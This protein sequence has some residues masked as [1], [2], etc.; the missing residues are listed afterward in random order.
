MTIFL[1]LPGMPFLCVERSIDS[2]R[3]TFSLECLPTVWSMGWLSMQGTLLS[4]LPFQ[5]EALAAPE[6]NLVES[7]LIRLKFQRDPLKSARPSR[8]LPNFLPL[9]PTHLQSLRL[10]NL[11]SLFNSKQHRRANSLE[12]IQSAF[13]PESQIDSHQ[14]SPTESSQRYD[15]AMHGRRDTPP[16]LPDNVKQTSRLIDHRKPFTIRRNND[17]PESDSLG[18][19]LTGT[20]RGVSRVEIT[21]QRERYSLQPEFSSPRRAVKLSLNSVSG[22]R[23]IA[24]S[25]HFDDQEVFSGSAAYQTHNNQA[26]RLMGKDLNSRQLELFADDEGEGSLDSGYTTRHNERSLQAAGIDEEDKSFKRHRDSCDYLDDELA[27]MTY[28][29]LRHQSF[30]DDPLKKVLQPATPLTG[31]TLQAKLEHF[32]GQRE[33]DQQKFFTQMNVSDWQR[34]GDWLLDRFGEVAQKLKES[35]KSKR[36]LVD[37]FESEISSR[38]ETVRQQTESIIKKL[39]KIKHK[40]EDMLADKEI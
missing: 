30:D 7:T 24:P 16:L 20:G 39:G 27:G 38:E 37:Q 5:M 36:D 35:R 28:A 9:N 3:Q 21:A 18:F 40:G 12:T 19:P 29:M 2:H 32:K 34:S 23:T 11:I 33:A 17:L 4:T 1:T 31:D 25:T 6:I 26:R 10:N 22:P 15:E 14:A 8:K 13:W